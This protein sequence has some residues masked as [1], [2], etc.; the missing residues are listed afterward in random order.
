MKLTPEAFDRIKSGQR[1]FEF[2]LN[3]E[4][5]KAL[6][7]G[8]RVEFAK[9]PELEKSVIVE[10]LSLNVYKDFTDLFTQAPDIAGLTLDEFLQDMLTHYTKD[11]EQKYGVVAIGIKV[12]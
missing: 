4:K 8:E 7:I 1:T 12:V 9:L 2:R 3:D 5:R 6:K 11:E 10:I